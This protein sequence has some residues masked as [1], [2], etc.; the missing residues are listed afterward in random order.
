[1]LEGK[2]AEMYRSVGNKIRVTCFDGTVLEGMCSEFSSAY[3]NDPEI[4]SITLKNGIKVNDN[5]ELY[6]LTEVFEIE[7]KRIEL[8]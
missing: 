8:I 5:E 4:A 7:I 1:M 6:P 2:E 3:D